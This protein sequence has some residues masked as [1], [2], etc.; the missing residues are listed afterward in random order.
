MKPPY[1]R[2]IVDCPNCGTV[3]VERKP[4][5]LAGQRLDS[6]GIVQPEPQSIVHTC[7][8][9]AKVTSAVLVQ[10]EVA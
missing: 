6:G 10:K 1:Y 5:R 9:H 2:V 4:H 8:Y 3:E 7:G